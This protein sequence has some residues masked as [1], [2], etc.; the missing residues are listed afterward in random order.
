MRYCWRAFVLRA[1]DKVPIRGVG[2]TEINNKSKMCVG[3]SKSNSRKFG[4]G[5]RSR[6]NKELLKSNDQPSLCNDQEFWKVCN[7]NTPDIIIL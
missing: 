7:V 5:S 3:N 2:S 4:L 6:R 1:K